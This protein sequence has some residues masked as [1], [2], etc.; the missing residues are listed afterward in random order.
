MASAEQDLNSNPPA[1]FLSAVMGSRVYRLLGKQGLGT[2]V[3]PP[4]NQPVM[5]TIGYHERTGKHDVT[6]VD[7]DQYLKFAGMHFKR[8][9]P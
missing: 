6:A 3:M 7:W 2:N 9:Q 8:K 4:L 1:E 5:G